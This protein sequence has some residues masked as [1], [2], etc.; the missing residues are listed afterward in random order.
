[1]LDAHAAGRRIALRTSGSTGPPRAVVRSAES[2][3]GS[4]P[5]VAA[6]T[7]LGSAAR[8][9]VPGPLTGTMNLFAAVLGRWILLRISSG[10]RRP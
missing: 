1:M 8:L 2:W 7:G 4:L 5:A 10:P 3:A 9:H 6:L